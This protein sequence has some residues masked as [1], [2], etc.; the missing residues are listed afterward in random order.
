M[1]QTQNKVNE[2]VQQPEQAQALPATVQANPGFQSR[3]AWE[4]MQRQAKALQSADLVPTQYKN[5]MGNCIIALD[6]AYRMGAAPLMVMQN[7]YIV[8]GR[9]GWSS[10]FLI[11]TFNK[12]GRYTGIKYQ[13]N[14]DRTACRAWTTEKASGERLEGTE[15]TIAMANSEG[16][17]TKSGSKWKTMP[18]QMLQYRAA[19]FLI[20]TIAPEI[21]MGL[22]TVEEVEDIIPEV[23]PVRHTLLTN[24]QLNDAIHGI[25]NGKWTK[26]DVLAKYP[27]LSPD[28]VNKLD[29]ETSIEQ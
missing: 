8:Q 3:D 10:Q 15:I 25:V 4:L 12:S 27:N 29:L 5:N 7:L 6:M 16:W 14:S 17:A 2:Q 18:E 21:S 11:A 13:F 24:M 22:H 20:R 19:A 28:Q 23:A 26:E 9:P 1:N